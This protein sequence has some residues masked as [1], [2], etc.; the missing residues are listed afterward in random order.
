[1]S[2][3]TKPKSRLANLDALYENGAAAISS[4]D[5]VPAIKMIKA[6]A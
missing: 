3:K 2:D 5:V 4:K 6:V 1:M